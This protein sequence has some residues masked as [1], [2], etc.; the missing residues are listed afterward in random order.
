MSTDTT[1]VEPEVDAPPAQRQRRPA[2]AGTRPKPQPPYAVVVDNDDE[3]TFAYVIEVIC[4][5]CGHSPQRAFELA[6]T[7][8]VNGRASVWS[9]MLEVA[10]L[11]RDQI[12]GY[13]PDFYAAE[14][15]RFPLSVRVEP[16]A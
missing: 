7:I 4:R 3:H 16:L 13:G 9:G 14:P 2:G 10:E 5:I 11:K 8:H 12:R 6:E 1:V 15:V